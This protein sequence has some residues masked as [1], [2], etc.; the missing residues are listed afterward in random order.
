LPIIAFT[1]E[2][3]TE[4]NQRKTASATEEFFNSIR[5]KQTFGHQNAKAREKLGPNL[6]APKHV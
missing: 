2:S 3:I 5:Q 1:P 6:A 4:V